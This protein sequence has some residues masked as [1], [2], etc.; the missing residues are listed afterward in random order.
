M[1]SLAT[2]RFFVALSLQS[3]RVCCSPRAF[4]CFTLSVHRSPVPCEF[5]WA[6]GG[7]VGGRHG[8][9]LLLQWL[10]VDGNSNIP[11]VCTPFG[12]SLF[13]HPLFIIVI[14]WMEIPRLSVSI[15]IIIF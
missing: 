5:F 13:P 4:G 11:L 1:S 15:E 10:I 2:Q 6:R 8:G 9:A 3:G 14:A 12:Q 7:G